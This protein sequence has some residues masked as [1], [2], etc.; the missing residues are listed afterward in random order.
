MIGCIKK[1]FCNKSTTQKY[2]FINDWSFE[3]VMWF[4][5]K[6]KKTCLK[7]AIKSQNIDLTSKMGINKCLV[8]TFRIRHF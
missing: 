3:K 5:N 7:L 2:L 1:I 4:A 6:W 8:E